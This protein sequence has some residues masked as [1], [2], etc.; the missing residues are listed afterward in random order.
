MEL[1][2]KKFGKAICDLT[3]AI[4]VLTVSINALKSNGNHP[5]PTKSFP[6]IHNRP[7]D[8]PRTICTDTNCGV[9][10]SGTVTCD[11]TLA[12]YQSEYNC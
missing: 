10:N 12:R 9:I 2:I 5:R 7:I 11:H 4:T 1:E 8:A 3:D 6:I